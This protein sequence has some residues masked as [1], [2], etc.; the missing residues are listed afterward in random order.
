MHRMQ[1]NKKKGYF[2]YRWQCIGIYFHFTNQGIKTM[3]TYIDTK[4]LIPEILALGWMVKNDTWTN[5]PWAIYD[6]LQADYIAFI[7]EGA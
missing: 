4:Q 6:Q 1:S 2:V 7:T 3:H 5:C